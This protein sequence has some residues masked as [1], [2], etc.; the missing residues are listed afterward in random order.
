MTEKIRKICQFE[1]W[2]EVLS[3][4]GRS[5]SRRFPQLQVKQAKQEK[6]KTRTVIDLGKMAIVKVNFETHLPVRIPPT[7][8]QSVVRKCKKERLF[9]LYFTIIGA[10]S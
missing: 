8:P 1:S 4:N 3:P 5:E 6:R 7:M 10:N 9:S 2:L